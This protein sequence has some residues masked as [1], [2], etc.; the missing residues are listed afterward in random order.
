MSKKGNADAPC[1]EAVVERAAHPMPI[2]AARIQ[3]IYGSS[4]LICTLA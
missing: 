3:I 4:S 1:A 2:I